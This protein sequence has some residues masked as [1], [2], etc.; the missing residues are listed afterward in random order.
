[1]QY[2]KRRMSMDSGGDLDSFIASDDEG[3]GWE[4]DAGGGE[5]DWRAALKEATGGYDPSKYREIDK[6]GD[7]GMEAGYTQIQMEEKRAA[8]IARTEDE[9]EAEAEALREAAKRERKRSRK[10]GV[11]AFVDDG[12]SD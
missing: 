1:M 3:E 11:A 6:L 4:S 10:T 5:E 12:S 8:R 7:R 2:N 9:R